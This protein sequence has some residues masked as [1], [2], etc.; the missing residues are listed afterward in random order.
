VLRRGG[1]W[2]G[3][4]GSVSSPRGT[5][6]HAIPPAELLFMAHRAH[7][8]ITE[9]NAGHLSLI[10]NPGAVARVI[11]DAADATTG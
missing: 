8:H 3:D 10:T 2:R 6:D 7:A 9:I 11:I 1:D 4:P 5:A